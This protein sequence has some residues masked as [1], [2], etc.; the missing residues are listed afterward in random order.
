MQGL[1]GDGRR[2][3]LCMGLMMVCVTTSRLLR[4]THPGCEKDLIDELEQQVD[5]RWKTTSSMKNTRRFGVL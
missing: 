5:R 2:D 3:A 1:G 4:I